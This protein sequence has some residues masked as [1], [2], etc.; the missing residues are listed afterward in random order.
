MTK[1]RMGGRGEEG[2][3]EEGGGEEGEGGGRGREEMRREVRG[4]GGK[5]PERGEQ[6]TRGDSS[7]GN[8]SQVRWGG[9][10]LLVL[11]WESARRRIRILRSSLVT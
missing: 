7:R 9:A 5:E 6:V 4:E 3:G 11:H 8:S 2:E 1:E 10:C